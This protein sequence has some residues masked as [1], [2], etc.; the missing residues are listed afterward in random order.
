MPGGRI[1]VRYQSDGA[2]VVAADAGDY[3]YPSDVRFDN[4][5]DRLFVKATG[6]PVVFGGVQTWLF[7]F[8]LTRREQIDRAKIDPVVLSDE[9]RIQ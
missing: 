5:K 2:D 6:M 9:C 1:N 7:E 8:D 3:I 4:A